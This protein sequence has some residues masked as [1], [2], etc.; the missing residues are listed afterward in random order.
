[1]PCGF[2]PLVP[3]SGELEMVQHILVDT[4]VLIDAGR[5]VEVAIVQ[6][7][8]AA[9]NSTLAVSIITQ[10]NLLSAVVIEQNCRLWS[11]F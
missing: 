1:M 5:A 2:A 6:L 8:T 9:Q 7:E 4:D 3:Q 11:V 10:M